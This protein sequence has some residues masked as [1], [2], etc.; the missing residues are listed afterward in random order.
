MPEKVNMAQKFASF[1]D[2]WNPKI[3]G[4]INDCY[5]KMVKLRGEFV[6]HHHDNEDELFLVTKG[7]LRM[8]LRDAAG[9]EREVRIGEGEFLIVP[10]GTEHL[11]IGDEEVHVVLLEPKTTLNTGNVVNERTVAELGRI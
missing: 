8:K 10:R 11:P 5:V 3:A 6:W 9:A 1:S 4:E 7:L 2:L